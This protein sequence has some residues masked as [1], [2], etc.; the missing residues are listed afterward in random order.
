MRAL[1]L[2]VLGL[3]IGA[4]G[5][6]FTLSALHR[7]TPYHKAV[8]AVMDHHIDA[9]RANMR[10]KQCDAKVSAAHLARLREDAGDVREAFGDADQGFSQAADKLTT[11]LDGAVAAAPATCEALATALK[12]VGEACHECHQQY[13]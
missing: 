12:P 10:A 4:L 6:T 13:R 1:L 5:A 11:A 9:L 7:G 3:A 2:V 8:M